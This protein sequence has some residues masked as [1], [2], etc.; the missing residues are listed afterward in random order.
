MNTEEYAW[1]DVGVLRLMK[2]S[3][4]PDGARITEHRVTEWQIKNLYERGT[5]AFAGKG[6]LSDMEFDPQLPA[7]ED[8]TPY[9]FTETGER[10]R[11]REAERYLQKRLL[12][13]GD[14]PFGLTVTCHET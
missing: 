5:F 3:E 11:K 6:R 8:G 9:R 12:P 13:K 2:R 4:V 7:Q 14:N 1:V 10:N